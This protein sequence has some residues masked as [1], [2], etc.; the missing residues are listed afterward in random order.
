MTWPKKKKLTSHRFC[1]K[2]SKNDFTAMKF[3][4]W[5]LPGVFSDRVGDRFFPRSIYSG[6]SV[7]TDFYET[8]DNPGI[9][10]AQGGL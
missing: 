4:T 6:N 10:C 1:N 8:K 2:H 3:N 5:F 9:L 7:T